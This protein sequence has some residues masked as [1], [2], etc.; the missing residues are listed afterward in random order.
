MVQ[1]AY[2]G[3]EPTNIDRTRGEM[4]IR[5]PVSASFRPT[6]GKHACRRGA[7]SLRFCGTWVYDLRK[8]TVLLVCAQGITGCV[9]WAVINTFLTDYLAVN[10]HLGVPGATGVAPSFGIGCFLGTVLGGKTGQ[11][12]YKR[13]K[14]LGAQKGLKPMRLAR[15]EE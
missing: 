5:P 12:L 3:V 1:R 4:T 10:A 2:R 8:P 6:R 14:I 11:W 15:K 7:K 9:P 13:D